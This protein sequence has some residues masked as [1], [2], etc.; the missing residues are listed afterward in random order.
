[1]MSRGSLLRSCD[2]LSSGV[3]QLGAVLIDAEYPDNGPSIQWC[4]AHFGLLLKEVTT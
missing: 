4:N 2:L 3:S 1:M